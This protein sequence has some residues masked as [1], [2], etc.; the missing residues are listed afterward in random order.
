MQTPSSGTAM[1]F[2]RPLLS[3]WHRLQ[4]RANSPCSYAP[5]SDTLTLVHG[6]ADGGVY[7]IW[8]LSA[9]QIPLCQQSRTCIEKIADS[10]VEAAG[11]ESQSRG[12]CEI[13]YDLAII[14]TECGPAVGSFAKKPAATDKC[15]FGTSDRLP[16]PWPDDKCSWTNPKPRSAGIYSRGGRRVC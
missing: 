2:D 5:L 1:N 6:A 11:T 7:N 9:V 16:S 4:A 13:P 12:L 3:V 8:R 10:K 14:F 15:R